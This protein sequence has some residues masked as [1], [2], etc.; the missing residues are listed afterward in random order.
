MEEVEKHDTEEDVWIVVSGKVYD[1]T[2]YLELHP[3]G[4]DSITMNAGQDTTEDF[5]AI[6]SKKAWK[7]L[8]AYYIG[9]LAGAEGAKEEAAPAPAP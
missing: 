2:K 8:D 4:V 5:E 6:H 7:L 1:V 9:E 3:G